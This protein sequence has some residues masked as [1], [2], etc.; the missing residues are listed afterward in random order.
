MLQNAKIQ[1]HV[2]EKKGQ[3]LFKMEVCFKAAL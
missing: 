1:Q 2:V 3:C